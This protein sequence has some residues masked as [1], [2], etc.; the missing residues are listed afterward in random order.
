MMSLTIYFKI[1][2]IDEDE[3]NNYR[4]SVKQYIE[5]KNILFV[6][7]FF[8]NYFAVSLIKKK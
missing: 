5:N 4:L 8:D 1:I 3:T 2:E 6:Y 7:C